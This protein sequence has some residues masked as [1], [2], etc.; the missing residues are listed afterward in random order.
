MIKV[1]LLNKIKTAVGKRVEAS[2]KK[3]VC[4]NLRKLS[5]RF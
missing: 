3:L 5:K 1:I 2:K 4:S